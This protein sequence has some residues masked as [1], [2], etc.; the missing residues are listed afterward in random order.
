MTAVTLLVGVAMLTKW[1][2]GT[3]SFQHRQPDTGFPPAAPL[4]TKRQSATEQL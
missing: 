3:R 4:A 2:M 1:T